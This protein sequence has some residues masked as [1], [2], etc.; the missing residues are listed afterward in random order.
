MP[1]FQLALAVL[2]HVPGFMAEPKVHMPLVGF[3]Y[4]THIDMDTTPTSGTASKTRSVLRRE[5]VASDGTTIKTRNEGMISGPDGEFAIS[6]T[7]TYRLFFLV[8]T[9]LMARP[10]PD[11]A[12]VSNGTTWDCPVTGLD[13][14]YPLG[15]AS[16]VSLACR[17]TGKV[18]GRVVRST[19]VTLSFSDLGDTEVTTK[20]GEFDVRK[21]VVRAINI[22]TPEMTNE[23]TYYFAPDLGISVVQDTKVATPHLETVTHAEVSEF[24]PAQ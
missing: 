17:V 19:P 2:L 23:I 6:G 4:T 16:R 12:L 3:R 18:G 8:D 1:T 15:E 13:R 24:T 11:H 14:F 9:E 7:T 5:V 21:L 22:N 20:A 10:A